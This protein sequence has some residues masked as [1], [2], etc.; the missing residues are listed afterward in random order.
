MKR[1]SFFTGWRQRLRRL[2]LAPLPRWLLE[3]PRVPGLGNHWWRDFFALV[4]APDNAD[5]FRPR[6]LIEPLN[7]LPRCAKTG[8]ALIQASRFA[9]SRGLFSLGGTMRI[10]GRD[11]LVECLAK[12]QLDSDSAAYV[13]AMAA[14]V[15]LGQWDRV[16]GAI[17]GLPAG[18][19]R[20]R[21][22]MST[23]FTTLAPPE[24]QGD[25]PLPA[26]SLPPDPNF[27]ACVARKRVAV[28]G[29]ASSTAGQG[30][31]IDGHDIV[32]RFN[33]RE[34]GLG[35]DP[36]HKGERCDLAYFNRAQTEHLLTKGDLSRFPRTL[37]WVIARRQQHA[38]A[39]AS[40]LEA[41]AVR[42]HSDAWPHRYRSTP[43]YEVP[44]VRG[45]LNAA[46]NA[47]L[48]ILHGGA[49]TVDVFHVDFMLSVGRTQDYSPWIKDFADAT[50]SVI[51]C[52]AGVH[53][54]ITQVAI[55]KTAYRSGR[56]H[57]D[58]PFCAALQLGEQ[59]YMDALQRLYGNAMIR[60][61]AA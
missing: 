8:Q 12:H 56:I 2:G 10:A 35:L 55:M 41:Q 29:P 57:G 24:L 34:Q 46:P 36:L 45:L 16:I 44:M 4:D 42:S 11:I 1:E 15:E 13:L 40:A 37:S 47:V 33:Y 58:E 32:V 60:L 25:H 48:D 6:T 27:A 22:A 51:K 3:H 5:V 50:R 21:Q 26:E 14:L 18:R 49:A 23:L 20:E 43:V 7:R 28:V 38:D 54:P 9:I 39:L 59:E 52:F 17:A 53:D 31:A 19:V 30:P 61:R